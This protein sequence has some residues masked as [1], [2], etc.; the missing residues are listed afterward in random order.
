MLSDKELYKI[1]KVK[2]KEEK[3]THKIKREIKNNYRRV[4]NKI[5]INMKNLLKSQ[6]II[7]ILHVAIVLI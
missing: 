1:F 4:R 7:L 5:N 6:T 2:E 3:Y